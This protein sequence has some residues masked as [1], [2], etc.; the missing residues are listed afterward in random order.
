MRVNNDPS[1]PSLSLRTHLSARSYW[2]QNKEREL[3]NTDGTTALGVLGKSASAHQTL[4]KLARHQP[5][6]KRNRAH[7]C[8]FW[9]K[10]ECTRGDLCPY[11]HEM[12]TDPNDP[13]A[14]QNMKDRYYGTNDPVAEK[15]MKRH[16]CKIRKQMAGQC[17]FP[18]LG[19]HAH[20]HPPAALA[21]PFYIVFELKI[22]FL[23]PD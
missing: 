11:R 7:I 8:S 14:K 19:H 12:P 22:S 17:G 15:Y 13:L 9:V 20:L 21:T 2:I 23:A 4:L 1:P 18:Q 3:A 16:E 10:G 6:Y 5:Y